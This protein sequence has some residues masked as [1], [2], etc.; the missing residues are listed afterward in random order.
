M[1]K[2]AVILNA[3]VMRATTEVW[4]ILSALCALFY[5]HF[6]VFHFSFFLVGIVRECFAQHI[7]GN[8]ANKSSYNFTFNF[9]Y[10]F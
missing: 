1:R 9:G 4:C 3:A 5:A 8:V 6:I 7:L 10:N 2:C